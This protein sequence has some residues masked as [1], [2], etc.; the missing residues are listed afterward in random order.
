MTSPVSN[1]MNDSD[2]GATESE[3]LGLLYHTVL[4]EQ[5]MSPTPCES[6]SDSELPAD[7][8]AL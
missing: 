2:R 8:A 1:T 6:D 7:F 4:S 5:V 3:P